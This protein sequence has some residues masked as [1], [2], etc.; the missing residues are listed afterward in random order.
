MKGIDIS[1]FQENI[2]FNAAK[3]GGVEAVYI[4]ATEG[5]NFVDKLAQQHTQGACG[6]GLLFGY[7]HF[8]SENSDPATQAVDFYNA[9]IGIGFTLVPV[10][11]IESNNNCRSATEITDRVLVFLEKFKELTGINCIIYTGGYFGRDLLDSRVK[12]YKAWIANYGVDTPMETGFTS[13]VGHQ[14]TERGSIAGYDGNI[15]MNNFNNGILMDGSTVTFNPT[16]VYTE[17]ST[18]IANSFLGTSHKIKLVQLILNYLGYDIVPDGVCGP[19]TANL[20]G[21]F[22]EKYNLDRDYKFGAQC[23]NKAY[24]LIKDTLCG[25]AYTQPGATILI[26]YLLNINIDG[27]FLGGTESAV[28]DF[29]ISKGLTPD[30]VVGPITWKM[31]FNR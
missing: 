1:S 31:L 24:E 6:A 23:F 2:D 7:Y 30:G 29:Q 16:P 10:L 8:M 27:I 19:I 4:K 22:Q 3:N 11:D 21:A 18:C 17:S 25:V 28:K 15:D 14:Y 13:V 12:G 5:V 9:I 20:V 26:Q